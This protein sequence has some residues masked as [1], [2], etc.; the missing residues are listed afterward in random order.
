MRKQL[1]IPVI[2]LNARKLIVMADNVL[3]NYPSRRFHC[4]DIP[5]SLCLFLVSIFMLGTL[6]VL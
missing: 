5:L 1:N 3:S 6:L 4:L 2:P